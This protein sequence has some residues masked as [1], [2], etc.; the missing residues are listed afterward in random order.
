MAQ[1]LNAFEIAGVTTNLEFLKALVSHPQVRSGEIDTGFIE[2]ELSTLTA[3]RPLPAQEL[4]AASAAVLLR[5][6]GDQRC[7]HRSGSLAL[8]PGRWLDDGGPSPPPLELP[9]G[10]RAA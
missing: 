1:A 4:A 2:R 7:G 10:C 8:G 3:A 6:Q 5:E 9:P